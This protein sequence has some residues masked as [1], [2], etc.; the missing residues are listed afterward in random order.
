MTA[1]NRVLEVGQVAKKRKNRSGFSLGTAGIFAPKY[2]RYKARTA[3]SSRT[4]VHI[5]RD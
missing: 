1:V 4:A 2:A 3:L 5:D